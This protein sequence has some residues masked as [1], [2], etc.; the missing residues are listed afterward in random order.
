MSST[1]K[2][3]SQQPLWRHAISRRNFVRGAAGAAGAGALVG[4]G[5]LLLPRSVF[6][7]DDDDDRIPNP[8]PHIT[9]LPGLIPFHSFFP[10]PAD[11]SAIANDPT[12]VQANG[13]DPSTIFDFRGLLAAVDIR[14]NATGINTMTNATTAYTYHADLRVFKGRFIGLDAEGHEGTLCFI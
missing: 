4:S 1:P 14:G 2:D 8:I 11:G 6:A 12:G 13:R 5:S 10:G 9:S 7:D 3:T